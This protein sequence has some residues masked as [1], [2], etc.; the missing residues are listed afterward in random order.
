[1]VSCLSNESPNCASRERR[2]DFAVVRP[3]AAHDLQRRVGR[4]ERLD[5]MLMKPA[6]R[7]R[8]LAFH[9]AGLQRQRAGDHLGECRFA[10]AVDAEKPDAVVDIETQ[11]EIAQ[12]RRA[13][14]ADRRRF[15]LDQGRRQRPRRRRQ[16]K[17]RDTLLDDLGDWFELGESLDA[18]LRLGRLACLGPEP[19]DEALQV[20]AFGLLLG[21]SRRLQPRLFRAPRFEFVV[22]AGVK[23]ELAVAQMQDGVDGIVEQFAIV[24]DDQRG[25]RIFLRAAP[26]AKARLRGRD[27]WSVRRGAARRA[28][29]TALPPARRAC[30]SRL[31]TPP[32][33]DAGRPRQNQA[34]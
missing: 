8:L 25:M 18:R 22:A 29:R 34:R 28:G 10:G 5:L 9:V 17:R 6:D 7:M 21:A 11:V 13:V 26:R 19:V 2:D 30:A 3:L 15:E 32:S 33:D 27:S 20:R 24:A 31:R 14:I 16:C 4:V 12:D 23:L 1:M